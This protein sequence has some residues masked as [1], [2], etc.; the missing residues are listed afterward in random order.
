MSEEE[1]KEP[2]EK[3]ETEEVPPLGIYVCETIGFSQGGKNAK[4]N[5]EKKPPN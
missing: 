2:E 1:K 4:S 5:E 3:K